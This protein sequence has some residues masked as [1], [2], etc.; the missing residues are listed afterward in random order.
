VLAVVTQLY[1]IA[2]GYS[3]PHK[4][5][6]FQPFNESDTIQAEIVRVTVDGRRVPVTRRWSGYRWRELVRER[7]LGRVH[8][9]MHANSGARSAIASLQTALDW[10]ADHTPR[11][12]ETLYYHARV[13]YHHNTRG[14]FVVE[15]QSKRR[16]LPSATAVAP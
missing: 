12:I 8:R 16:P 9:T 15:L 6:A 13:T 1:F 7:G 14:P 2:R 4:H 5:F 11:D 3:D 10:V